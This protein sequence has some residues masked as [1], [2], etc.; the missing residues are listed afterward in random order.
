MRKYILY[1]RKSQMDKDFE[2]ESVEETLKRH[3]KRL[4]EFAKATIFILQ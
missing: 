3:R 2:E 1:L 4:T